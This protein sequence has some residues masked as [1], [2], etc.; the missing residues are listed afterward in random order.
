LVLLIARR[1]S[2][3]TRAQL[4]AEDGTIFY[5]DALI[6]GLKAIVQ[7]YAGYL[8]VLSRTIAA[9]GSTQSA[10]YV[11][12]IYNASALVIAA[13]CCCEFVRVRYRNLL[14]GDFLR[15]AICIVI[16]SA[17]P[18]YGLVG[19]LANSQ[20]FLILGSI[21]YILTASRS[22][23]ARN[24]V[25]QEC[26][27]RASLD[28]PATKY[29]HLLLGLLF[30]LSA[31]ALLIVIPLLLF[32]WKRTSIWLTAGLVAGLALQVGIFF[33]RRQSGDDHLLAWNC[34]YSTLVALGNQVILPVILGQRH[35]FSLVTKAWQ[36][37]GL[38]A[39]FIAAILISWTGF[40]K[41]EIRWRL[42]GASYLAISSLFLSMATRPN[43]RRLLPDFGH[44][45]RF[46][47]DRYFFLGS[48]MVVYCLALIIDA[49][50]LRLRWK[51]PMFTGFFIV[52]GIVNFRIGSLADMN[53]QRE[54]DRIDNWSRCRARA[55][56][57]SA[58][59][60]PV[61]PNGWTIHLPAIEDGHR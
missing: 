49:G 3:L 40:R 1:P 27:E 18:A 22:A 7:P 46:G 39:V 48:C 59:S 33:S 13:F 56:P 25:N 2:T 16:A 36:Y 20:W 60:V 35:A 50:T 29:L 19:N 15:V 61:N 21:P 54:A 11:P 14:E 55:A 41:P 34:V 24:D 53:W 17:V 4:W 57:C 30:G 44:M 12:F 43:L 31:P 51:I 58:L 5:Q 28:K 23:V 10:H 45:I 32:R 42:F 47:A 37:C 6:D 8:R 52:S 26:C 38:F 9:A